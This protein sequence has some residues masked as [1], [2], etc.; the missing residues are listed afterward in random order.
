MLSAGKTID[1]A[2]FV[3]NG[4]CKDF[5]DAWN[6]LK[7]LKGWLVLHC[8]END[9]FQDLYLPGEEVYPFYF[10]KAVTSDYGMFKIVGYLLFIEVFYLGKGPTHNA[11]L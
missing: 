3:K 9:F 8:S 11:L 7:Q 2:C 1:I 5:P 10:H 6:G 4:K